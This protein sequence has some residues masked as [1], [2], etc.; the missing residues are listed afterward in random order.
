MP[1]VGPETWR[2]AGV[3][4]VGWRFIS[5]Y[6]LAYASTA[7]LFLAPL[8]VSLALKV[9]SLV[10]LDEAPRNLALVAGVGAAVAIVANP[11]FGRLSDRTSS[12]WGKRRP[13]MLAGLVGGTVGVLGVALADSI[14]IV[15][16]GW[17]V[18]QLGFNALFAAMVAVLPDQVPV[19]QR[20]LVAGVLGLCLPVASV[21]GTFLVTLFS[22]NQVA[23]FW[24][25][26]SWLGSS[27]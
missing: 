10:G 22:G 16:L 3:R 1:T 14:L 27:S 19:T 17:C 18:A 25:R 15:L 23:M 12:P 20:G 2:P 8:L 13:W 26:A 9:N 21:V 7:L 24:P 4:P 5:L 6:T 11:F